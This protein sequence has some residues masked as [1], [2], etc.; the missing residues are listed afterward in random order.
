MCIIIHLWVHISD[1]I[2]DLILIVG[3]IKFLDFGIDLSEH[4]SNC[5]PF[6]ES[7]IGEE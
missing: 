2:L 1:E 5:I 4:V 7:I 3:G 6:A